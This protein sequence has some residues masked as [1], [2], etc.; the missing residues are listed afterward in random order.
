MN[1]YKLAAIH[2]KSASVRMNSTHTHTHT[3]ELVTANKTINRQFNC[4][5]LDRSLEL[6]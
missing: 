6:N 1:E 4:N 5:R 3:V 2:D